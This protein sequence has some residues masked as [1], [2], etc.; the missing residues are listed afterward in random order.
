M[1]LKNN[2]ITINIYMDT[3]FCNS[4]DIPKRIYKCC[5]IKEKKVFVFLNIYFIQRGFSKDDKVTWL[6]KGERLY[7]SVVGVTR[8]IK[9]KEQT[10][11]K[12][13]FKLPE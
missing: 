11:G 10:S 2:I 12:L 1:I 7:G 13:S 6:N 5:S 9:V 3:N 4:H 8:R